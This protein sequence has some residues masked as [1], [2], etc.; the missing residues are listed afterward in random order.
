[1][2]D[3]T[4]NKA[5][6]RHGGKYGGQLLKRGSNF[7]GLGGPIDPNDEWNQGTWVFNAGRFKS[8]TENG[9]GKK[10]G[11]SIRPRR[12]AYGPW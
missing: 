12:R 5:K 9:P 11:A 6:Y 2:I 4:L 8:R 1:M 10:K 7:G 3:I